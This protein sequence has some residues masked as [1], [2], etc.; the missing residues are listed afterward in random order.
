MEVCVMKIGKY[1]SSLLILGLFLTLSAGWAHSE[2][3]LQYLKAQELFNKA[4]R[5]WMG[6]KITQSGHQLK[7]EGKEGK[8]RAGVEIVEIVNGS[9]AAEAGLEEG[10]I[11][12]RIDYRRVEKV[13]DVTGYLG[14]KKPGD[15]IRIVILRDGR[16]K[17]IRLVLGVWPDKGGS[18]L[19]D[20]YKA[21]G[22]GGEDFLFALKGGKPRLGVTLIVPTDQLREYFGV[23]RGLGVLVSKVIEGMPAEK[24]GLRAGDVILAVNGDEIHSTA[25][26]RRALDRIEKGETA[27]IDIMRDGEILTLSAE[28]DTE[29]VGAGYR[30]L[31]ERLPGKELQEELR[32]IGESKDKALEALKEY[33]KEHEKMVR[34]QLEKQKP[35]IKD[36]LEKLRELLEEYQQDLEDY[37]KNKD[38]IEFY[39][40][41]LPHL[42]KLEIKEQETATYRI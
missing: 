5:G 22:W 39:R 1:L 19:R 12:S 42:Q 15:A 2:E 41:S 33:L 18:V 4:K 20:F 25:D 38:S 8:P 29:R 32:I 34:E 14:E 31:I 17:R 9:P 11:I 7:G 6:V 36:Y 21:P 24:A 40:Q 13:E 23:E 28:L 26:L 3:N 27:E 35:L 10:D 30:G 16:E 37:H